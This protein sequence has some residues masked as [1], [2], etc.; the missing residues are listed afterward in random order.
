M[1]EIWKK[2][3]ENNPEEEEKTITNETFMIVSLK[4][5]EEFK[6]FQADEY[7]CQDYSF[8]VYFQQIGDLYTI[9]DLRCLKACISERLK[10]EF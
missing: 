9:D 3:T 6:E 10:N 8:R 2:T 4:D 1:F 5:K 7:G